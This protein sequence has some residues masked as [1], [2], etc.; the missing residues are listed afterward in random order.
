MTI[1][2]QAT[3][4]G[5]LL[6]RSGERDPGKE[7]LV[8]PHARF[9]Y[10]E[11]AARAIHAARGLAGLGVRRGD[12]VGLLM[13]NCPEFVFAFFGAQLLGAVV[14]PLNTRYRSR[15]LAYVIEN[16]DLVAVLTSDLVDDAVDFVER[17]SEALP[18]LHDAP[19][20]AALD[21]PQ[22]PRLR[23]VVLLGRKEPPGLLPQ[24]RFD[25]LAAAVDEAEVLDA[26]AHVRV[27]DVGLMLFTSGTTANPK[28]CLL[29][30]ES[31]VRVWTSAAH[32]LEI[33]G[34]DRVWDALPMF[35]M[36]CLGP[37]IFC[38]NLGGTLISM[39]HFEPGAA[40]E[41]I[42]GEGATWM[43]SVFPPIVMALIK[44]PGF[45]A[46]RLSVRGLLN[47]APPDTL[48]LIQDAFEPAYQVGGHFGMT[49]CAG[50]ITCT[51]WETPAEK[52]VWTCGP[53]LPGVEVRVVDPE[54]GEEV[55]P[56]A[57]GEL[58]IRGYGCFDGYYKDPEQTAATFTEEGWLRSGDAGLIDG[59]GMI[60]YLG[61][62]KDMLKVGGENVAPSEIES[63]LST[64]PAVKLVQ[65]VGAP[66]ERLEEVPAAFIELAPGQ[67][68]TE[69][70]AITYCEGQVA[71]F[72]VPRYVRFVTE[73]DWPMSA[74]KIQKFRLQERI[75]GE[76]R[77]TVTT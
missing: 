66:D 2:A 64:H 18:A 35:H 40:L 47:V 31:V 55:G 37:L 33:T 51:P 58:Q 24:A 36:S 56:D 62:I 63:H 76:L 14:V 10:G 52:R 39:L 12:H 20:P 75:A 60:S 6:L 46:S 8:F 53:P 1:W 4:M 50:A 34:E 13:P 25:E 72:K 30:H 19:D 71:S 70:E 43:Y 48:R 17:L 26:R 9:T 21:L 27:R 38:F 59:D 65:V 57:R 54:T 7:A 28:G 15:E 23:S 67:H 32:T 22:A 16:A 69:E 77:E 5:D 3:T 29:T 11:V 49:E 73:V 41:Q 68:L 42:E 74:T 44:H 45:E 61:R